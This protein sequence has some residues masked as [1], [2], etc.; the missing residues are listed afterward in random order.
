MKWLKYL[1]N[2]AEVSMGWNAENEEIAKAE[3]DNGE[4]TIEDDGLPEP[5]AEPTAEEMLNAMLE[6]TSYE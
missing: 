3:A 6:V 5:M 2:G 1:Y 4:Y